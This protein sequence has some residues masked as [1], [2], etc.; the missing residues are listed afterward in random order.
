[1]TTKIV[2]ADTETATIKGPVCDFALVEIDEELNVLKEVQA[3]I[4]P[5]EPMAPAAQAIHGITNEMVADAPTMAEY[6]EHYG[7]PFACDELILIGHNIKFDYKML[8]PLLPE[9]TTQ[10]CT[11]R[12]AKNLWP[13]LDPERENHKLGTLA[14]M[15]GLEAGTAHRAMGDVMTA[16][17]LLRFIADYSKA[18]SFNDLVK[19]GTAPLSLDTYIGFGKYGPNGS[20]K[21]SPKGTKLRELPLDYVAWLKRQPDMDPDLLAALAARK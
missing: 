14:I 20:D 19:M 10:V 15:F 8:Q 4:D 9:K 11:L 1:M 2:I 5:M 16:L 6:L 21:R 3:L 13:D 17:N 12:M 18:T 7:N